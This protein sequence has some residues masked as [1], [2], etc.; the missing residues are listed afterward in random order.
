VDDQCNGCLLCMAACAD[1]GFHAITGLKGEVV[2]IDGE[3]CDG[4][5][6]CVMVCP[7]NSI[8]MVPR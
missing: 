8:T 6:L 5:G 4:C 3:R 1:G 2:T 7:L